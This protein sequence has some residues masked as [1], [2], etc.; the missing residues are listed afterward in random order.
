[1]SSLACA[2]VQSSSDSDQLERFEQKVCG[3]NIQTESNLT[4]VA[5]LS[6]PCLSASLL[7]TEEWTFADDGRVAAAIEKHTEL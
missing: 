4:L 5:P 2:V 6:I 1:M 7:T 3:Y